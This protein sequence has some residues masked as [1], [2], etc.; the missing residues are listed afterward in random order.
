MPMTFDQIFLMTIVKKL[1][2][3]FY[4]KW[5]TWCKV[6]IYIQNVAMYQIALF[7]FK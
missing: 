3:S 6:N 1:K 7:F 4:S 5:E 2:F